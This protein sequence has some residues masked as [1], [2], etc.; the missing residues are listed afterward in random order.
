MTLAQATASL[1]VPLALPTTTL[2]GPS[3]LG[4]VWGSVEDRKGRKNGVVAVTF[5]AQG[6]IVEY[7]RPVPFSGQALTHFRRMAQGMRADGLPVKVV[8]LKGT[9]AFVI[10][11]DS[12]QTGHNFGVVIFKLHGIEVSVMGHNDQSTLEALALSILNQSAGSPTSA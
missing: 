8:D 7:N 5:P 10:R 1:G 2:V 3:D 6:V 11:Q 9:P 4:P 12:D